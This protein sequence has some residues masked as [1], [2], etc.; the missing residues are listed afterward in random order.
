MA[1]RAIFWVDDL[2]TSAFDRFREKVQQ[3]QDGLS[4]MVPQ[5]NGA[6]RFKLPWR[7]N[8]QRRNTQL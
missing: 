8:R 6:Q 7:G 4:R 5:W 1:N 3:Y 2:D